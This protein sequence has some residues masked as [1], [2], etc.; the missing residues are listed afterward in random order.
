MGGAEKRPQRHRLVQGQPNVEAACR[1]VPCSQS[2]KMALQQRKRSIPPLPQPGPQALQMLFM[3]P[4]LQPT[5]GGEL[6]ERTCPVVG[7]HLNVGQPAHDRLRANDPADAQPRTGGF[8]Q[9]AEMQHSA[10]AVQR[11]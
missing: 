10:F 8:R 2:G 4:A 1:N 11:L 3:I 7:L 6:R 5:G 9:C